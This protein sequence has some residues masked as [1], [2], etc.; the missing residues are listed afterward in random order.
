MYLYIFDCWSG[1]LKANPNKEREWSNKST[2]KK[3]VHCKRIVIKKERGEH[4][5]A[6]KEFKQR[7][8][9]HFKRTNFVF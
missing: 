1:T 9:C 5:C 4:A 7:I 6:D 3:R 2:D 8:I